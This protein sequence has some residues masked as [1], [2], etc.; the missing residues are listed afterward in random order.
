MWIAAAILAVAQSEIDYSTLN[1]KQRVVICC[2]LLVFAPVILVS[3]VLEILIDII[4][5]KD[6]GDHNA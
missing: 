4:I 6:N 5:G 1:R 3:N 2:L